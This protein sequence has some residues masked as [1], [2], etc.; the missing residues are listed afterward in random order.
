MNNYEN[1]NQIS[2]NLIYYLFKRYSK[3]YNKKTYEL[4][5]ELHF[6]KNDNK[7]YSLENNNLRKH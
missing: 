6:G 5:S 1:C 3:N 4:V 2:T 7:I